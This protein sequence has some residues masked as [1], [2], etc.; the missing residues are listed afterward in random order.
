MSPAHTPARDGDRASR[1]PGRGSCPALP[2]RRD[3]WH[4]HRG[5]QGCAACA[6]CYL[7]GHRCRPGVPVVG[8][9]RAPRGTPWL[10]REGG[11]AGLCRAEPP[12]PAVW[13]WGTG[14]GRGGSSGSSR[15]AELSPGQQGTPGTAF[16]GTARYAPSQPPCTPPGSRPHRL[17]LPRGCRRSQESLAAA[18]PGTKPRSLRTVAA[19]AGAG[20]GS[21]RGG[22]GAVPA[23][24]RPPPLPSGPPRPG[25]RRAGGS[26]ARCA[27]ERLGTARERT[28]RARAEPVRSG[29]AGLPVAVRPVRRGGA[30]RGP[31]RGVPYRAVP[32]R[33]AEP[34]LSP[35]VCSARAASRPRRSPAARAGMAALPVLP[36]LAALLLSAAPEPVPRV[37]L[38]YGECPVGEGPPAPG[39]GASP[40]RGLRLASPPGG[41]A[42]RVPPGSER[43][44][45]APC[46]SPAG[47]PGHGEPSVSGAWSRAG[48]E[49]RDAAGCGVTQPR[50]DSHQGWVCRGHPG[51]LVPR[52]PGSGGGR[53]PYQTGRVSRPGHSARSVPGVRDT[54]QPLCAVLH[55]GQ[56]WAPLQALVSC[57][58]RVRGAALGRGQAGHTGGC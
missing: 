35:Q 41:G 16:P 37:S 4:G 2:A 39:R 20:A 38:P 8:L 18:S 27:R 28:R 14:K 46:D 13:P 17:S 22:A 55:S 52:E 33:A 51:P 58:A 36:V 23:G 5:W 43:R 24:I 34:L 32:Y 47:S 7:W 6:E 15:G 3:P 19:G 42:S 40:R 29:R 9:A 12:A 26:A 11:S 57:V 21:R 1:G 31:G 50:A 54:P 56:L 45:E 48:A 44:V 10:P 49:P 25:H 30:G 53:V